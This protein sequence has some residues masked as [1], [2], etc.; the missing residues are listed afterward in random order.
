M[1]VL[2]AC[3]QIGSTSL[4]SDMCLITREYGMQFIVEL[5]VVMQSLAY[6][7]GERRSFESSSI[8][9]VVDSVLTALGARLRSSLFVSSKLRLRATLKHG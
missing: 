4:M 9:G 6:L 5:C 7:E 3:M 2:H 1:V 8:R